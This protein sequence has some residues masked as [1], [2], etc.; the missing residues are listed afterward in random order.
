MRTLAE[1]DREDKINE[2]HR[3]YWDLFTQISLI[4]HILAGNIY[5]SG[6]LA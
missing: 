4:S 3:L 1:Q 5:L 6:T 2:K